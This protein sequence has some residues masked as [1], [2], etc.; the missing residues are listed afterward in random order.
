MGGVAKSWPITRRRPVCIPSGP[1]FG[2]VSEPAELA[3]GYVRA[4]A[5]VAGLHVSA[6]DLA[7]DGIDFGFR[8][9]S[10]VFPAVEARVV[11]TAMPRDED[12]EEPHRDD[13]EKPRGA[14]AE[15]CYDGLDEVCFNKLA[16]RDFTVPR[17]LF[18]LALPPDKA[19]ASFQ[20][21]GMVL[22]HLGYFHPM[23]N[24]V[25]VSAPDRSKCRQVR[26][27]L[28]RVLTDS[29]LRDLLRSVR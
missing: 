22:R 7:R 17:Y 24:E 11:W 4:L 28:A 18:L 16:G 13:T 3:R 27:S 21:D 15:W 1:S 2:R 6:R 5:S 26:I 14:E 8:F 29:T 19:Y 9:P 23:A 12:A 20:P 25:P 10:S